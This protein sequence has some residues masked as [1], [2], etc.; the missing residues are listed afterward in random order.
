LHIICNER[1]VD[2]FPVCVK[3]SREGPVSVRY[4]LLACP[5]LPY[6]RTD[7]RRK[8]GGSCK[9]I[10][11]SSGNWHHSQKKVDIILEERLSIGSRRQYLYVFLFQS[12]QDMKDIA[13]FI[14]TH[15]PNS[16]PSHKFYAISIL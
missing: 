10:L 5:L 6:K 14:T 3:F 11:L 2:T 9:G 15:S 4:P 13:N 8:I 7:G 16:T 1:G 12:K